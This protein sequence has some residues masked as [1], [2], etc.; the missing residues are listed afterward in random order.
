MDQIAAMKSL[1]T[2]VEAGGFSAA[3]E[4]LQVSHTAV[5]RQIKQLEALLGA[6]LL[7]RTTRRFALTE[8]GQTFYEHS[9]QIL[10]RLEEAT[11]AVTRHQVQPTGELRINAPMSFGLQELAQWLPGFIAAHPSLKVDLVCNDR[12]VDLIEEGFD[13]ALRLAYELSDSTLVVKRLATCEEWW[14][15]SPDYARRHGTPQV[16][17]DLSR[18]NCMVYS[19]MQKA[20]QP[21]F[22][23]PDARTYSVTVGGNLQANSGIALRAAALAG[24]G[25]AASPAFLVHEHV[26]RGELVRVLAD[27]TQIPLGLYALYPQ[28]RHLSPKVRAFVDFAANHYRTAPRW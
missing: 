7:N 19:L 15:A 24:L 13:V 18:H 2:V 3:A 5:S 6:Q 22:T 27:Y 20:R 9:K 16:P 21:S 14:V 1:R 23:G 4:I 11:L 12:F 8:A 17:A 26:A 28:S 25:L 10:D